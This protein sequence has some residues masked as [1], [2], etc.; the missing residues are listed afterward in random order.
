MAASPGRRPPCATSERGDA[1]RPEPSLS[2]SP[3]WPF[4]CRPVAAVGS[5]AADADNAAGGVGFTI[6]DS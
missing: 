2:C 4:L 1:E 3:R 6:I 5:T